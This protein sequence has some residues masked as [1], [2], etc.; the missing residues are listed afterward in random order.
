MDIGFVPPAGRAFVMRV[1]E[2]G[3]DDLA[4]TP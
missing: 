1:M 2:R 4:I 3:W